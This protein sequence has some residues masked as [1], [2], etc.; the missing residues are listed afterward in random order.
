[1]KSNSLNIAFS[2]TEA[3][4]WICHTEDHHFIFYIH[5]FKCLN[6]GI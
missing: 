4:L 6:E 5:V 2:R 1:M 3:T